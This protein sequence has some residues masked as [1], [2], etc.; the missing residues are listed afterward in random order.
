MGRLAPCKTVSY[1]LKQACRNSDSES[2]GIVA[3]LVE[4]FTFNELVSGS[5]P[6]GPTNFVL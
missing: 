2:Y 1:S 5:S 6:D 3:Q 4:R